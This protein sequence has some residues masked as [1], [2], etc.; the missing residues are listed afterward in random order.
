MTSASLRLVALLLLVGGT[1][2]AARARARKGTVAAG[3]TQRPNY[4]DWR[5][6]RENETQAESAAAAVN[7]KKGAVNKVISMLEDLQQKVL[8]EGENEARTYNQFA[9]FCKDTTKEKT[10]AITAGEDRKATLSSTISD[11]SNTRNNLDTAI[12][13]LLG[14]I[15]QAEREKKQAMHTRSE[16]LAQYER[17]SM[18]LVAAIQALEGAIRTLK[19]SKAPASLV[20]LRGV[21][22]T[23]ERATMLADALGLGGGSRSA[24]HFTA[25]LQQAPT[26]Q[27]EDYKYHSNQI[28]A[29]LEDLLKDFTDE[30][31]TVDAEEV[32]AVAAHDALVQEKENLLKQKNLDLDNARRDKASTQDEIATHSQDLSVTSATLLDDQQY[33]GELSRMCSDKAKT[34]DQRS[35]T[36]QD[37]L[38]ALTAAIGIV[39]GFVAGN[40]SAATVRFVQRGVSVRL[41]EAVAQSPAAL[42]AMEV[43]A[44]AADQAAAPPALVQR[45][46]EKRG[47]RQVAFLAAQKG[48]QP[49]EAGVQRQVAELLKAR[50]DKLRSTL[51]TSLASHVAADP[52]AKVKKLIED[53]INRLLQEASSESSQKGFCDKSTSE[54]KQKRDYSS[55]AI[56]EL[57]GKMME[58][59]ARRDEMAEDVATLEREI[60]EIDAEVRRAGDMRGEEQMENQ[61]AISEATAGEQATNMA[62]TVLDR[63]YKTVDDA[64]VNLTLMQKGP[65]DD[66]PDAGFANGEAYQAS[67]GE[68]G[69]IIGMLEVIK[70]DFQRTVRVTAQNEA[71]AEKDYNAFMTETGKSLAEKNEAKT[72][73]NSYKDDAE[74]DLQT[75]DQD[76]SSETQRLESAIQEL[77]DLKPV[78][79][80]TT[81]SYEDRV[82]FRENE[83]EALKKAMC[84]L[85][86]YA[87][88]GPGGGG[89]SEC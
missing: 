72:Q 79:V 49:G 62:I 54:A 4:T 66:A 41:A 1:A 37:E 26:V 60:D 74:A 19:A 89:S 33:L 65:F 85:Q 71:K 7:A 8:L 36:R 69:G 50:G 81:M 84:I 86:E 43:E 6:A 53:L 35:R 34:W 58:L 87:E 21:Q 77:L 12:S 2:D 56:E 32:R 64:A 73:K 42:E 55:S 16:E 80:D 61:Y 18:D 57:N 40:T 9:C 52:F 70:S 47:E 38:S 68:A 45:G 63:Y 44:E 31:N 27:M 67:Q 24:Q 59:E 46:L 30:K 5:S 88:Y 11:L 23:V 17:N 39:Q 29:T 83:I 3:K 48:R 13:G 75:A 82:A 15:E 20:Q 28:T 76:L 10:D 78:C 51:L 25:L 14:D 22:K